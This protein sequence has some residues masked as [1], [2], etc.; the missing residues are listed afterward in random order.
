VDV[1]AVHV[2]GFLRE[3]EPHRRHGIRDFAH[4]ARGNPFH[5][6]GQSP[7]GALPELAQ[8]L[9]FMSQGS[10]ERQTA[11]LE[12]SGYSGYDLARMRFEIILAPE[13]VGDLGKLK[14]N[15]RAVIRDALETHLRHDPTKTSRSRIKRLRGLSKPQYR[16]RVGEARVFY[17]VSGSTVEVLAIVTKSEAETWLGQFGNPE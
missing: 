3:Q 4:I 5:D 12:D 16:L 15:L 7:G 6:A 8:L 11:Y 13:A 1:R 9:T 10:V 17:D 14:A 2:A